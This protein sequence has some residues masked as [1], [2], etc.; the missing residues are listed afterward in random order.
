MR[1]C[2]RRFLL[3][4]DRSRLSIHR[5]ALPARKMDRPLAH[6]AANTIITPDFAAF[7]HA[8]L[9]LAPMSLRQPELRFF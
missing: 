4:P 3:M 6:P 5:P 2:C 7:W 1:F 9:A 8:L